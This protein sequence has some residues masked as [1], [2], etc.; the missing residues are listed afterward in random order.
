M[1]IRHQIQMYSSATFLQTR[2][3]LGGNLK[4]LNNLFNQNHFVPTAR[5]KTPF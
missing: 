1:N 4:N 5:F 2:A 3:V